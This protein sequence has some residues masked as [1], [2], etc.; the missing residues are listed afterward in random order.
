M[1]VGGWICGL[2]GVVGGLGNF[3]FDRPSRKGE[4][5]WGWRK[6]KAREEEDEEEAKQGK[7]GGR[8]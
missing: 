8:K 5:E 6:K 2:V 1:A 3:V 4:E 7:R